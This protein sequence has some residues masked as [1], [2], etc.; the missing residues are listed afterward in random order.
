MGVGGTKAM[1][2]R[3]LREPLIRRQTMS[4]RNSLLGAAGFLLL[5][6]GIAAAAPAQVMTDLNVRAGQGT[7]YPVIGVLPAGSVVDVSGCGDGWCYVRGAGGFAS[8]AY[9]NPAGGPYAY[10]GPV[11]VPGPYYEPYY[12]DPGPAIG[13]GFGFG[14]FDHYRDR[15]YRHH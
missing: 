8:A 10:S 3:F 15:H 12:Y 14:R 5:S 7:N 4:I 11:V 9:L 13:F 1:R 2:C 6:T